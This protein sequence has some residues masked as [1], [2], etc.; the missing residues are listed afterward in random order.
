VSVL[1]QFDIWKFI[2]GLGIFLFGMYLL[3]ESLK[4]LAGRT[5]KKFL[6][7]NTKNVFKA[8][9][10]GTLVTAVLQ[11]S[12]IVSLMTLAFVGAGIISMRNALGIIFGSNLGT[13]FTGWIVATLGFKLNIEGFALPMIGIGAILM[14]IL[15]QWARLSTIGKA[16][17]G[18]GFLFLG[19]DYMKVSIEYLAQNF[20]ITQFADYGPFLFLLVGFVFTAIIQSSSAMM[21]IT[22]SALSSGIIPFTSAAAMVIGSDLGTTITALIGGMTGVA[23]KKQVALGHFLFNFIVDIIAFLLLGALIYLVKNV[24][25]IKD[26]VMALVVFHST[27]NLMGII[28]FLPFTNSFAHFL[29]NRFK[30]DNHT[31]SKYIKQVTAEV[32][33]A[34]LEALGNE[35]NDLLKQV[36]SLH[37]NAFGSGKSVFNNMR[38]SFKAQYHSLKHLEG[39][40]FNFYTNLQQQPLTIEEASRLHQLIIVMRYALHAAKGIKDIEPNLQ[41]FYDSTKNELNELY[42]HF[43]QSNYAFVNEINRIQEKN[44][45]D[46]EDMMELLKLIE[47]DYDNILHELNDHRYRKKLTEMDISTALTVNREMFSAHRS[48]L[49]AMAYYFLESSVAREFMNMPSS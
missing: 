27:F 14:V 3:E 18:F 30:A 7:R 47:N 17:V 34:A 24:F 38:Y 10:S 1:E 20:D 44:S 21:V 22:L 31:I 43:K 6:K 48:L 36:V 49:Y 39:E 13:T 12:S 26:D 32:P 15:N 28:L 11:S 46:L 9:L 2:A 19:L 4:Q 8:I 40:M 35:A 33:E 37:T 16:F 41:E 42:E 45:L 5:F 29:E 25:A 23:A